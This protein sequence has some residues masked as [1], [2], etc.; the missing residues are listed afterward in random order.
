MAAGYFGSDGFSDRAN[1]TTGLAEKFSASVTQSLPTGKGFGGE[2]FINTQRAV[3]I[4]RLLSE[5]GTSRI[6]A[7]DG[8]FI[9]TE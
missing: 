6:L 7:E 4:R 1:T 9:V 8:S 2:G 3:S 5:N